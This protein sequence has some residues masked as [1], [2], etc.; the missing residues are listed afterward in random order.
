MSVCSVRRQGTERQPIFDNYD[1]N[2]LNSLT[3]NTGSWEW[4]LSR[5]GY[6]RKF[7]RPIG[8]ECRQK[9]RQC[10]EWGQDRR[11]WDTPHISTPYAI[12]RYHF[13]DPSSTSDASHPCERQQKSEGRLLPHLCPVRLQIQA[14]RSKTLVSNRHDLELGRNM[15]KSTSGDWETGEGSIRN[16]VC[17]YT[18]LEKTAA[19][20]Y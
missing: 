12:A 11:M 5:A 19:N 14:S 8:G 3:E 16:D 9:T 4:Q 13:Q 7:E 6:Q 2:G 20:G 17:M 10:D 1:A 15:R 18:H